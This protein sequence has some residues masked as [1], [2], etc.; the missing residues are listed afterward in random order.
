MAKNI[1][2]VA[3]G[4]I[5]NRIDAYNIKHGLVHSNIQ[6]FGLDCDTKQNKEFRDIRDRRTTSIT[7]GDYGLGGSSFNTQR[8]ASTLKPRVE[9][10]L[11]RNEEIANEQGN[12]IKTVYINLY[13]TGTSASA[14]PIV[15][16]AS[17]KIG[18]DP[19]IFAVLP[20][21]LA[22]SYQHISCIYSMALSSF[23][24]TIILREE[25]AESVPMNTRIRAREAAG[26]NPSK[27]YIT[28]QFSMKLCNRLA[29]IISGV[30]YSESKQE[31]KD[32]EDE[33]SFLD[34]EESSTRDMSVELES[35]IGGRPELFSLYYGHTKGNN[36]EKLAILRPSV[37]TT[38]YP[39]DPLI[40]AGFN[41]L[42]MSEDEAGSAIMTGLE[43]QGLKPER[44]FFTPS[45]QNEIIALIPTSIPD[46]IKDL[47]ALVQ[48]DKPLKDVMEKLA[49][50]TILSNVYPIRRGFESRIIKERLEQ[51]FYHDKSDVEELAKKQGSSLS[52]D[53]LVE[54]NLLF[55]LAEKHGVYLKP[56][57]GDVK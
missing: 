12:E 23:F 22:E 32:D 11:L 13:P 19:L 55:Y 3:G 41:A 45:T 36:F 6:P 50:K 18:N 40:F 25:F 10:I 9:E 53:E 34:A 46:R 14:T 8:L 2:K 15:A 52:W 30:P 42:Q 49:K 48:R 5:S 29:Q 28:A 20:E 26:M 31:T 24:S 27:F 37:M 47:I 44:I 39:G 16:T 51:I 54:H 1:V 7:L 4:S 43:M 38:E 35:A 17:K 56:I 21:N 57:G 33:L